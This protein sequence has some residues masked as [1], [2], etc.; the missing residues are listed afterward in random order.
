VT[1]RERRRL[2]A[3]V[4][5]EL[6]A[7][8]DDAAFRQQWIDACGSLEPALRLLDLREELRRATFYVQSEHVWYRRFGFRMMRPLFLLATLAAAGFLLQRTIDPAL[9]LLCFAGGAFLFYATLQL[10]AWR[11]ARIDERKLAEIRDGYRRRLQRL[12]DELED[13]GTIDT[14]AP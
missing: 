7:P 1:P 5:R 2:L 6:Q 11:W 10:F 12:H 9:G 4:E 8:Q 3:L 14:P 13:D